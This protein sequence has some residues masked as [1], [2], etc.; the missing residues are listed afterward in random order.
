MDTVIDIEVELTANHKGRFT[1]KICPVKG[2]R[3]EATQECL[4]RHPLRQLDGEA[5]FPILETK[6]KVI[7]RRRAAL[8]PGLSCARCVLQWTWT[9]ANS[10]GTCTN[11]TSGLGCGAQE[12]FR[13]CADVRVVTSPYFLPATDNPRAIMIRDA[14]AKGGQRALVVRSQVCIATAAWRAFGA[15]MD[16]WCQQNCLNYPPHCPATMCTCPDTCTPGPASHLTEFECNKRCLRFPHTEQCPSDCTCRAM[17]GQDFSA[18]DAVV[19]DARVGARSPQDPGFV[20]TF[21]SWI[22]QTP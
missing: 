12:T 13:N 3:S 2:G 15:A 18:M 11:G 14:A 1:L 19:V 9:S 8:P 22:P 10:W 5:E 21:L 4:D 7:V 17:S 20:Q 6:N 16:V